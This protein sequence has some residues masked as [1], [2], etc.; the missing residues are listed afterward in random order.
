MAVSLMQRIRLWWRGSQRRREEKEQAFLAR[1]ASWNAAPAAPPSPPPRTEDRGLRTEID[2]EGLQAAYL[3]R[4]G[5]IL[6]YLDKETGEV[7]ESRS[8]LTETRY[9]RVPTQSDEDD[10]RAFLRT[11]TLPQRAHFQKV[12]SFRAAVAEDRTLEKAW[13]NFKNDRATRA[14]DAWLNTV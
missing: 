13:Y 1:S 8:E 12:E 14:I 9:A 2:R 7:V 4:S 3:D 11:L 10:Q 5:V 6:Y